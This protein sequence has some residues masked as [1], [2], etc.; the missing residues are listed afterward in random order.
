M[1]K[2]SAKICAIE[3]VEEDT[4]YRLQY[5]GAGKKKA[6]F[7]MYT[8]CTDA[9]SP[10][11][12]LF[13]D[14]LYVVTY[15]GGDTLQRDPDGSFLHID[16]KGKKTGRT[17]AN[18]DTL[19][20]LTGR[21]PNDVNERWIGSIQE[22]I[23]PEQHIVDQASELFEESAVAGA[24]PADVDVG[25]DEMMDLLDQLVNVPVSKGE[26]RY[27]DSL[28]NRIWRQHNGTVKAS[29]IVSVIK[30]AKLAPERITHMLTAYISHLYEGTQD[31]DKRPDREQFASD[32]AV[33]KW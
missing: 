9:D 24:I 30:L 12:I 20:T 1:S 7:T 19:P 8:E 25:I 14:G 16:R 23:S 21:V 2:P 13:D 3:P 6:R 27:Y 28:Y 31:M 32:W 15:P 33:R 17:A 22:G 18:A 29:N 11:L 10:T 5:N 4:G 26:R